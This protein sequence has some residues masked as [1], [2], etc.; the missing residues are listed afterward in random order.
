M[1]RLFSSLGVSVEGCVCDGRGVDG[2]FGGEGGREF[3][4]PEFVESFLRNCGLEEAWTGGLESA[5]GAIEPADGR[6]SDSEE[7][8]EMTDPSLPE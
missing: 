4:L 1:T 2:E 8:E 7:R 5:G 6:R 3:G